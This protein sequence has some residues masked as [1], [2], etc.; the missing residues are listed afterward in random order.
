[1]CGCR[2]SEL[3][4]PFLATEGGGTPELVAE[5]DRNRCLFPPVASALAAR[6]DKALRLGHPAAGLAVPQDQ[7]LR[8][9]IALLTQDIDAVLNGRPK[10]RPPAQ[11]L[12]SICFIRASA[13]ASC[14]ST[15]AQQTYPN[16]EI[17]FADANGV[18]VDDDLAFGP[19]P[20]RS[21]AIAQEN[22]GA[23]RNATAQQAKGEYLFFVDEATVTLA[24]RLCRAPCR[25]R[26]PH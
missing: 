3:G 24:P 4:I 18:E 12:V 14:V 9:W 19:H 17:L 8:Q 23:A 26:R 13:K 5:K 7:T 21:I 25:S 10:P 15:V 2:V 20:V 22:R 16:I 11:P 6:M 1:M